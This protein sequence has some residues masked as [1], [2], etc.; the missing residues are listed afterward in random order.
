MNPS[1]WTALAALAF[2][3]GAILLATR[4]TRPPAPRPRTAPGAEFSAERAL[5]HVRAIAVAPHPIG[6]PEHAR[7]RAYL[8]GALRTLGLEPVEQESTVHWQRGPEARSMAAVTNVLARIPGTRG[9]G[10]AVALAAHYDSVP[11]GPGAG[12]DAAG[13]AALLETARALRASAP[14]PADVILLFTDGEEVHLLGAEAFA[15]E[16]PWK[17]DVAVVLNFEARGHRGP[18][19]MFETSTGN[20]ALIELLARAGAEPVA[21]SLAYEVYRRLP[22]DTD[23]TVFKRAGLAGLNFAFV[24]GVSHYHTAL[25]APEHLDRGSLQHHGDQALA[26]ARAFGAADL[27][28]APRSDHAYF[29]LL[30]LWLFHYPLL[31]NGPLA[32]LALLAYALAVRAGVRRGWICARSFRTGALYGAAALALPAVVALAL[33]SLRDS[34][35][36]GEPSFAAALSYAE[37]PQ[38][39]AQL[40]LGTSLAA[41]LLLMVRPRAKIDGLWAGALVWWAALAAAAPFAVPGGSCY[42]TWPLFGASLGLAALVRRPRRQRVGAS[43]FAAIS[44][45]VLPGILLLVPLAWLLFE[46]TTLAAAHQVQM[47]ASLLGLLLVPHLLFA[48]SVRRWVLPA[49][50]GV[51][52]MALLAAA[53]FGAEVDARRPQRDTLSYFADTATGRAVFATFDTEPDAWTVW[54]LGSEP[55]RESLREFLPAATRKFLQAPAP[56][57]PLPRATV[58]LA[59]AE[60]TG[61][62]RLL[63]FV[64]AVPEGAVRVTVSAESQDGVHLAAAGERQFPAPAGAPGAPKWGTEAALAFD[65]PPAGGSFEVAFECGGALPLAVSTVS[66]FRGLPSAPGFE[67]P[68]RPDWLMPAPNRPDST[69]VRWSAEF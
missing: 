1:R 19:V 31:W 8:K 22:N 56:P 39:L 60:L 29:S 37:A 10:R 40:L 28:A 49:A 4:E 57:L 2:L 7:V 17:Q 55:V 27:G 16:H 48:M 18:S 50:S 15:A 63:R 62:T 41:A 64:V 52:G 36:A 13:V 30:R 43:C 32:L 9:G 47:V 25:D 51:A 38:M 14:L 67:P 21:N 53:I 68:P 3:A 12:D 26:L 45:G 23:L 42:A 33:G 61:S 11:T 58:E 6:S 69:F 5:E 65:A 46:A 59:G 35:A 24:G 34:F 66:I 54:F 44:A 20:G